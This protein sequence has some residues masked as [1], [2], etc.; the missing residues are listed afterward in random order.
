MICG[1]LDGDLANLADEI[2]SEEALEAQAPLAPEPPVPIEAAAAAQI[3]DLYSEPA[4]DYYADYYDE[5]DVAVEEPVEQGA[6]VARRVPQSVDGVEQ[7]GDAGE[8]AEIL[9]LLG[10]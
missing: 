10:Q 7:V 9:D 6:I 8:P 2:L 3:E 5:A 4:E 1:H